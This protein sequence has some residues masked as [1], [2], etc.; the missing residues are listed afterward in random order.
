M[1]TD[2]KSKWR[3]YSESTNKMSKRAAPASNDAS[4]KTDMSKKVKTDEPFFSE[5]KIID[6]VEAAEVDDFWHPFC[7]CGKKTVKS[8]AH[9]DRVYD[10][11]SCWD[12]QYDPDTKSSSGGCKFWLNKNELDRE[13]KCAC[14][15]PK[16]KWE[17]KEKKMKYEACVYAFGPRTSRIATCKHF[18]KKQVK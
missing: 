16:K 15:Y 7:F 2:Y 3:L 13:S 9:G 14:G 18:R 5:P 17:N 1:Q 12:R 8:A 6:P 4:E 11:F 10:F